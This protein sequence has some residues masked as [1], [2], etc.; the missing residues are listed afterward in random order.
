MTRQDTTPL[1]VQPAASAAHEHEHGWIVESRHPTSDGMVL[2]VRCGVCGVRRL[3]AQQM[4]HLPPEAISRETSAS[5]C[6]RA[7]QRP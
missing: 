2:Y 6:L 3:D 5:E 1:P 4:P 7:S